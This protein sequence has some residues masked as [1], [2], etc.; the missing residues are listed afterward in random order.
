MS[1]NP[2]SVEQYIQAVAPALMQGSATITSL[3]S[4]FRELAT[5]T[6]SAWIPQELRLSPT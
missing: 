3:W 5:E 6:L 1:V 2:L 4:R